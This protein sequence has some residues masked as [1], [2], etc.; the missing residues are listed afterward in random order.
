MTT[1]VHTR[2][3]LRSPALASRVSEALSDGS[4][5]VGTTT[6]T[7]WTCAHCAQGRH[8]H[9]VGTTRRSYRDVAAGTVCAC[10]HIAH[11]TQGKAGAGYAPRLH[12][13]AFTVSDVDAFGALGTRGAV[14][15]DSRGHIAY[16][17]DATRDAYNVIIDRVPSDAYAYMLELQRM[18]RGEHARDAQAMTPREATRQPRRDVAQRSAAQRAIDTASDD[19]TRSA[20]YAVAALY[21]LR[22]ASPF[23]TAQRHSAQRATWKR[24]AHNAQRAARAAQRASA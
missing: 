20:Q 18:M 8:T 6:G 24:N 14:C 21:A 2:S 3:G 12:S 22:V 4:T 1:T 9:C 16:C 13:D 23:P 11:T 10:S 19:A 7:E 5:A 15:E 17:W